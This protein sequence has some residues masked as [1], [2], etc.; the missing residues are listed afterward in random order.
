MGPDPVAEEAWDLQNSLRRAFRMPVGLPRPRHPAGHAKDQQ[1]DAPPWIGT[2]HEGYEL[3]SDG[4]VFE[5]HELRV[6][7][8]DDYVTIKRASKT[9]AMCGQV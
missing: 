9:R 8:I 1:V 3:R 6:T 4:P 7:R 2:W 5:I